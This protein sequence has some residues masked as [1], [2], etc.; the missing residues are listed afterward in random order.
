MQTLEK[1]HRGLQHQHQH[2][3]DNNRQN[4]RRG[5]IASRQRRQQEEPTEENV[6]DVRGGRQILFNDLGN[7]SV[8]GWTL[9]IPRGRSGDE[10]VDLSARRGHT[11]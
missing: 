7:G 9:G 11:I 10:R 3:C 1:A 8:R 4:D 5:K 2:H 6:G